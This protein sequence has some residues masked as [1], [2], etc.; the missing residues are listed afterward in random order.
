MGTKAAMVPGRAAGGEGRVGHLSE[1]ID[2]VDAAGL[3]WRVGRR[4]LE[5]SSRVPLLLVNGLGASLEILQPLVEELPPDLPVI[6]FD[7]P[8]AGLS[9]VPRR[10]LS[11]KGVARAVDSLLNRLGVQQA[12][13]LGVSWG[14][15]LAQHL[16]ARFPDRCRRLVL[17][18]TAPCMGARPARLEVAREMLSR[19]RFIDPD[20]AVQV[21]GRL[22]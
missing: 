1:R 7:A 10:P 2:F 17:V 22:Y 18:S 14:G 9:E 16:A 8:G 4:G 5:S 15:L 3:T 21:A 11:L 12:D 19:R 6:R 20:Y 13:V